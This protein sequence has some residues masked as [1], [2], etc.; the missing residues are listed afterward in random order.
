VKE[1]AQDIRL[2][3]N[4][5][6]EFEKEIS[7]EF[8]NLTPVFVFLPL[9]VEFKENEHQNVLK[10]SLIRFEFEKGGGQIDLNDLVKGTGSFYMSFPAE[11]FGTN[12]ELTH[13]YFI[14]QSPTK[15]I[16]NETF[17]MGCGKWIDIKSHFKQLQKPDYLKLNTTELRHLRVLAGNYIFVFKQTN[18]IYLTQ[19][20]IN[21][22]RYTNLL[23]KS[24][25]ATE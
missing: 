6:K 19:L 9:T 3:R 12:L 17:G 1:V 14:S 13:L 25:G 16:A 15:K 18:Q 22:S 10:D 2:P 23:C 8:K 21:D 7:D 4:L 24:I 5:F 11:Q 20:T